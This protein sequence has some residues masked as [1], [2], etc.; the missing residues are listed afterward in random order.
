MLR[1]VLS[2][3]APAAFGMAFVVLN[4][5]RMRFMRQCLKIHSVPDQTSART[6]PLKIGKDT[7][8]VT[9]AEYDSFAWGTRA[10]FVLLACAAVSIFLSSILPAVL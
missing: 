2:E 5:K 1:V 10:S 8:Y 3:I 9:D 7:V 6:R 4:W